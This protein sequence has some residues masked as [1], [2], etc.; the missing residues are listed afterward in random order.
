MYTVAISLPS[1]PEGKD[2]NGK[3]DGDCGEKPPLLTNNDRFTTI[4]GSLGVEKYHA[5]QGLCSHRSFV[6]IISHHVRVGYRDSQR[7][8]FLEGRTSLRLPS[9]INNCQKNQR[10]TRNGNTRYH[11]SA[12]ALSRNCNFGCESRDFQIS[13]TVRLSGEV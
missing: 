8:R 4:V 10:Q 5:E 12:I 2:E 9:Y 11:R 3:R 7:R 1:N 13:A 6:N